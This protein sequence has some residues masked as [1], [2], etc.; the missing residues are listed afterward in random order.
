VG[1]K[2]IYL[3]FKRIVTIRS[4]FQYLNSCTHTSPPKSVVV[5]VVMMVVEVV[6]QATLAA[7]LIL[8]AAVL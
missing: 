2:V 4:I 3:T 1:L 7:P 6:V 8:V 5:V